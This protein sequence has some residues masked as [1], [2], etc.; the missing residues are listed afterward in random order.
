MKLG[1]LILDK[2]KVCPEE[3]NYRMFTEE[4]I[5]WIMEKTDEEE[6]IRT[7]EETIGAGNAI[8]I[9]IQELHNELKLVDVAM[10]SS[11]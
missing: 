5:K 3:S 2:I 4:K 11:D 6:D 9:L 7:L 1:Y 8:E 10:G